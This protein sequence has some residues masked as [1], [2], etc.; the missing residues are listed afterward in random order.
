MLQVNEAVDSKE[1]SWQTQEIVVGKKREREEP[2][3]KDQNIESI[4]NELTSKVLHGETKFL[5]EIN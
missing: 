2:Q 4:L 5:K 1:D 3:V